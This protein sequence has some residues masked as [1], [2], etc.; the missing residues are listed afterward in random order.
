M[1][2]ALFTLAN[3]IYELREIVEGSEKTSA[4]FKRGIITIKFSLCKI[5]TK[6]PT[7]KRKIE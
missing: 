3:W 4:R 6:I 1:K 5:F 2:C 7:R